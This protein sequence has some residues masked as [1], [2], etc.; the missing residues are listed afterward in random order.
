MARDAVSDLNNLITTCL[1]GQ[2]GYKQAAASASD[3]QLKSLFETYAQQRAAYATDLQ[4]AVTSLGG[5]PT[6]S[7]SVTA[8][9]HRGWI[10]LKD[11]LTG[12]DKAVLGECIRGEEYAVKQ[13]QEALGDDDIPAA[14]KTP[15][16]RQHGEIEQALA[17]MNALHASHA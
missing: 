10:G 9:F 1:D 8:A 16:A 6:D 12:G 15:L 5:T 2:H 4:Q 13:Y 14:A 17:H 3:A 7:G 11:A